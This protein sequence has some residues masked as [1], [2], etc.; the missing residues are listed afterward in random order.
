MLL[1]N[2]YRKVKVPSTRFFGSVAVDYDFTET[3]NLDEVN[4]KNPEKKTNIN[5]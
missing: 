4:L 3:V 5:L 2:V 1:R